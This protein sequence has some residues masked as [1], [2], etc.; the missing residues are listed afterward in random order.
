[1]KNSKIVALVATAALLVIG[2]AFTSMAATYNWYQVDGIWHCKDKNGDD[3]TQDWAKSGSDLYWLDENGEMATELLI[4]DGEN[5]Y[6]VDGDGKAVKNNWVKVENQDDDGD[7][8]YWYYFQA[9]GKALKAKTNNKPITVNGKKYLFDQDGKM[10]YGWI[11]DGEMVDDSDDKAWQTGAYYAGGQ[12]DGAVRTGVWEKIDVIDETADFVDQQYWFYFQPSGVKFTA[13]ADKLAEKTVNGKKYAFDEYGVMK[14]EWEATASPNCGTASISSYYWFQDAETG[15]KLKKGWFRV[16]PQASVNQTDNE[17][18]TVHWYYAKGDGTLYEDVVKTIN[19]KKYA[20]NTEGEM[21]AGLIY[22]TI[23]DGG[24]LGGHYAAI[25]EEAKVGEVTKINGAYSGGK[26]YFF[27]DEETDG[28]MKYGTIKTEVDG[29]EYT[30][31]FKSSGSDKGTGLDG[32]K[33]NAYYVN[34]AKVKA[35]S[36]YKYQAFAGTVATDKKS[37]T[38]SSSTA[39]TTPAVGDILISSTGAIVKKGTKKDADGKKYT[40][41]DYAITNIE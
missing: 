10:L 35:D 40:V 3:I 28:S 27:G 36:D 17:D 39:K 9:S 11:L 19:G 21:M 25:D 16:I 24:E 7:E 13:D 31:T 15:A 29:D 30:F 33:N 41:V 26:L 5:F 1:M 34:G 12:D 14:A 22:M 6:Y 4:D 37:V 8:Y 20:F 32:F 23:G 18:E 2:A 38:L